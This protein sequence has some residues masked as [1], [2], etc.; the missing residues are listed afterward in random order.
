[1]KTTGKEITRTEG[2]ELE[3][4]STRA[5]VAPPVDI[6]ENQN[7]VLVVADVPGVSN[8]GLSLNF[9]NNR[10]DIRAEATVPEL[11]GA[12][13][14]REFADVDYRR[15]FELAPGIDVE[16]IKAELSG[17]TLTIHLPK[18]A[19]LKPRKIPISAG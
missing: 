3:Q 18:S 11:D 10:L 4:T 2:Q 13:M 7:E 16:G 5:V 6:Y 15:S 19:A 14:F 8:E 12:A 17:G 9:E 1:M